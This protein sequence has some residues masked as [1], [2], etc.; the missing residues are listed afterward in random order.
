MNILVA[1]LFW[2]ILVLT[3][4]TF[5]LVV[6]S[7]FYSRKKEKLRVQDA[8]NLLDI[9]R[10]H[11][12]HLIDSFK[13]ATE[14][15]TKEIIKLQTKEITELQADVQD[16]FQ[17]ADAH[18]ATLHN[19]VVQNMNQIIQNI[20]DSTEQMST[21]FVNTNSLI[22]SVNNDVSALNEDRVALSERIK[23]SVIEAVD[24]KIKKA[25]I[26]EKTEYIQK[27]IEEKQFLRPNREPYGKSK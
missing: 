5:G 3:P 19:L 6:G 22:T 9:Q 24:K 10:A 25:V 23:D 12:K 21:A 14:S 4:I 13:E 17:M 18:C 26:L 8:K 16:R 1:I 27:D 7:F 15:Q 2:G 11:F 20:T